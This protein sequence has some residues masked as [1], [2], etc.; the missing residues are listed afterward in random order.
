MSV[1][2][3]SAAESFASPRDPLDAPHVHTWELRA[4]EF[5][6]FGQVSYYECLGCSGARYV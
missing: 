3:T 2:G 5:D 4:V 1:V 6:T